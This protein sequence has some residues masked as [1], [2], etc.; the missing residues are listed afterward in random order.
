MKEEVVD[1][2][3]KFKIKY[4]ETVPG[5][6]DRALFLAQRYAVKSLLVIDHQYGT[7][8]FSPEKII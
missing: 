7:I 1:L 3:I 2:S 6:R 5:C 8:K 4:D